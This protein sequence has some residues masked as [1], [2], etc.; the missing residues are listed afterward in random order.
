MDIILSLAIHVL[1]STQLDS[2]PFMFLLF[3][4]VFKEFL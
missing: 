3:L 4:V 1:N 2:C